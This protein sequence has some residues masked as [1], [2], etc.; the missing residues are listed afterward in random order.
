MTQLATATYRSGLFIVYLALDSSKPWQKKPHPVTGAAQAMFAG[1]SSPA[2]PQLFQCFVQSRGLFQGFVQ[3]FQGCAKQRVVS[4]FHAKQRVV[5]R[6]H[7]KQR[8]VSRFCAKQTQFFLFCLLLLPDLF[9]RAIWAFF[10]MLKF[11]A[12][13]TE[14]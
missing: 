13:E 3:L 4:R 10:C 11:S 9:T 12:Y 1:S 14:N 6:F 2:F 7:A 8:V 5:S